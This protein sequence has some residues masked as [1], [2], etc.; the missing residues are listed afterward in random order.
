[1]EHGFGHD[2]GRQQAQEE[3][4]RAEPR[5]HAAPDRSRRTA[6]GYDVHADLS[7][8]PVTG[9]EI[10]LLRAFLSSEINAIL[11]S[12]THDG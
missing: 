8:I 1:M 11:S 10:A 5:T 3:I 9:E 7:E 6:D 4:S 12:E 2:L